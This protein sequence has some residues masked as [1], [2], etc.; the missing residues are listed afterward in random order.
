MHLHI[1]G[2][3]VWSVGKRRSEFIC[4]FSFK[5]HVSSLQR[6]LHKMGGKWDFSDI[7]Y[8]F[9]QQQEYKCSTRAIKNSMGAKNSPWIMNF[10]FSWWARSPAASAMWR[11]RSA[12]VLPLVPIPSGSSPPWV[13]PPKDWGTQTP[14]PSRSGLCMPSPHSCPA[15]L[16]SR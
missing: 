3:H 12:V 1:L 15:L 2:I 8:D 13:S 11:G 6:I 4:C 10:Y 7:G 14:L 9:S 5:G 16:P